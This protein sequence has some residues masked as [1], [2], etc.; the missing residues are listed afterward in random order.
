MPRNIT[1]SVWMFR[2][3]LGDFN[4]RAISTA[5]PI[6]GPAFF[7]LY[8]IYVYFILL[9]HLLLIIFRQIVIIKF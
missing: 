5:E 6:L 4:F 1:N 7:T 3:I 9:V 8:V 2:T